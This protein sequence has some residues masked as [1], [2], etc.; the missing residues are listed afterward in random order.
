MPTVF[1]QR[2]FTAV[3]VL[4]LSPPFRRKPPAAGDR[5]NV[6]LPKFALVP[7]HSSPGRYAFSVQPNEEWG[8][9]VNFLNF[10]DRTNEKK[11]RATE[12]KLR[13]EILE[14]GKKLENKEKIVEVEAATVGPFV[15]MFK[16]QFIWNAGEYEATLSVIAD[17]KKKCVEKHFRFTLF[18]TDSQDLAKVKEDYRSGDGINWDSGKHPGVFVQL[19][20]A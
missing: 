3:V 17:K 20:E 9:I 12:L 10:F 1:G 15:E 16:D 5:T 6:V 8:H 19:S 7:T 14:L 18:E 13:D 11:Y 2:L 4:K